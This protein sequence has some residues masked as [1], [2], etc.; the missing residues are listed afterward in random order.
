MCPWHEQMTSTMRLRKDRLK[1]LSNAVFLPENRKFSSLGVILSCGILPHPGQAC[2]NE[3][4]R[5]VWIAN[6]AL[7]LEH[8]RLYY[9][10]KG[11]LPD[12]REGGVSHLTLIVNFA[13]E[14]RLLMTHQ[15]C[16]DT[17][18]YRGGFSSPSQAPGWYRG[19]FSFNLSH[20]FLQPSLRIWVLL[21]KRKKRIS[22]IHGVIL[23]RID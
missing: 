11:P 10:L 13:D 3:R 17:G 22:A 6:I 7:S 19:G 23:I 9:C 20:L 1:I 18:W 21:T 5:I 15:C 14:G 2:N 8:N 16:G 4:C 12:R